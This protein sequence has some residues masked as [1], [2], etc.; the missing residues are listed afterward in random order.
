MEDEQERDPINR[1]YVVE[2][3]DDADFLSFLRREGMPDQKQP[4]ILFVEEPE[5]LRYLT[6][7]F[8]I[9]GHEA[10]LTVGLDARWDVKEIALA[11][12]RVGSLVA[13]LT[14]GI[15]KMATLA[16]RHGVPL[17][18]VIAE[19]KDMRFEPQGR[20]TNTRQMGSR[21]VPLEP[22]I[23]IA[24][25]V[26]DYI[27]RWLRVKFVRD[28]SGGTLASPEEEMQLEL[29]MDQKIPG[30]LPEHG[31]GWLGIKEDQHLYG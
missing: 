14:E 26:L 17:E 4:A 21:S 10:Y 18:A 28:E 30:P 16:L 22:L 9:A 19:L 2:D 25:S 20:V 8:A 13:G 12:G 29:E 7:S 31:P 23:P 15:S 27:A 6:H 11:F 5:E 24:K 1:V 3:P